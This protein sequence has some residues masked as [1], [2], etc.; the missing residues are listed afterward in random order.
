MAALLV[1]AAAC[2]AYVPTLARAGPSG[3][4]VTLLR[5]AASPVMMPI[6]VPKV[7][8]RPPGAMVADWVNLYNRMYRERILFLGKQIDDELANEMIGIM[9]YLDSEDNSKQISMYINSPGGSVT[10]GFGMF[11]TMRHVRR[12][13]RSRRSH[14]HRMPPL[15][16]RCTPAARPLH[17]RR[18]PVAHRS[19]IP[20]R[21]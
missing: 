9:L 1:A 13:R 19:P 5:A 11:D 3:S 16:A 18:A 12:V 17:A 8:Y 14:A 4:G 21:P 7:A 2:S 10:A 20:Y 15:Q 6:G